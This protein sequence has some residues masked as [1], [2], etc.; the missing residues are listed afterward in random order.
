VRV[1]RSSLSAAPRGWGIAPPFIGQGEGNLEVCRTILPTCRG[2]AISVAELTSVLANLA[3]V[4][5]SWRVLCPYRSDFEGSGAKVGVRP[6]FAGRL[7]GGVNGRSYEVQ[8]R[9]WRCPVPVRF[10]SVRDVAT[11]SG[12]MLQWWGWPHRADGD[13]VDHSCWPDVT[14]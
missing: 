2:I 1:C 14:A 4:E 3:P 7:E 8:W 5:A 13:G 6:P 11:V 10:N 9:A 12:V